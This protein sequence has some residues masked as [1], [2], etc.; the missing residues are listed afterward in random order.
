MPYTTHEGRFEL[1]SPLGHVP[2]V[3]HPL[4]KA[5]LQRYEQ[6]EPNLDVGLVESLLID[7][8]ALDGADRVVDWT[9]SVDGSTHEHEIDP[10]FPSTRAIFLQIAGVI[11]DLQRL[12]TRVG[13]YADPVAIA[14]AQ[15]HSVEAGFLPSGN[16]VAKSGQNSGDAFREEIYRFFNE[17]RLDREG[18]TLLDALLATLAASP[19][20][21]LIEKC[22]ACAGD[23]DLD[24]TRTPQPCPLCQ[25]TIYPTDFLRAHEAH[26]PHGS[27]LTA[28][29]RVVAAAE[30][31]AHVAVLLYL[32]KATPTSAT[33]LASTAFIVDGPL[34]VFGETQKLKVP[35]LALWQGVC[36]ELKEKSIEPPLLVGV[37]KTGRAAE[38][39]AAVKEHVPPGTLMKLP[40]SYIAKYIYVGSENFGQD[41]Y[42]GRKWLYKT[43]DGRMLVISVPPLTPGLS[44]YARGDR[45]ET[46]DYPTLR[47]VCAL[48]D[49]VGTQLFA[50][51]LIPVALAHQWAAYPLQT[52][53]RVFRLMVERELPRRQVIAS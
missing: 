38:Y 33:V 14:A 3:E 8:L 39:A 52:A 9:I 35:L 22:A 26:D 15:Q 17:T 47:G 34:A 42:Y 27:N 36:A 51:A 11:V 24:V 16:L 30:H 43:R 23:V 19:L 4:V 21:A 50:D 28:A 25:A 10:R 2:T 13:P 6:V 44:P 48:L 1:A 41:T 18:P 20:A 45:L 37:E 40:A 46:D 29:G 53:D 7:S 49:R 31:L 32:K 12:A 5:A